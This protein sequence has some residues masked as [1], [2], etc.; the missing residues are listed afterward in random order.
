MSRISYGAIRRQVKRSH[1]SDVPAAA[2]PDWRAI[3][4]IRKAQFVKAVWIRMMHD[5][6]FQPLYAYYVPTNGIKWGELFAIGYGDT[7][8]AGAVLVTADRIPAAGK[9]EIAY[10]LESFAGRLPVIPTDL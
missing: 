2:R 10:W 8:P 3:W 7:I 9:G 6:S 1:A 4:E 5:P